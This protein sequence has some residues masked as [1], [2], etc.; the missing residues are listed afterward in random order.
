MGESDSLGVIPQFAEE[1]F[2]RIQTE[3]DKN[4]SIDW[5][6]GG[7]MRATCTITSYSVHVL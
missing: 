7:G 3:S 6:K 2:E 1:L 4:V 5:S